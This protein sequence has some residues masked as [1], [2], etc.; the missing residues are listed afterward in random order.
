MPHPYVKDMIEGN[1]ILSDLQKEPELGIVIQPI[2]LHRLRVGVATDAT[3]GNA[4][5]PRTLGR[6][7]TRTG[8]DT[9]GCQELWLSILEQQQE[10]QTFIR[11]QEEGLQSAMRRSW[12][13]SGISQPEEWRDSHGRVEQSSIRY[14]TWTRQRLMRSS[15]SPSRCTAKEATSCS[16]TTRPW[17]RQ[18]RQRWS[19][20]LDGF[21][22]NTLSA[23]CQS[24]LHGIGGLHWHRFLLA[25]HLDF[26]L[27]LAG[28]RSSPLWQPPIRRASMTPLP[29]AGAIRPTS[30]TREL[31]LIWQS[32]KVTWQTPRDKSA[33]W[34]GITWSLMPLLNGWTLVFK[35]ISWRFG[36]WT[37][38]EEGHKALTSQ[39]SK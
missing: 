39:L 14:R 10:D 3:R 15:Y 6:R 36:R 9:I 7:P 33:G 32:S 35:D 17:R 22:V 4:K 26:T 30:M 5:T 29:S 38:T 2:P 13:T 31:R 1:Q 8:S 27:N 24:L 34:G 28:S 21:T 18:R 20:S 37:L 16:T 11:S 25:E 23:A 19:Q 12:L